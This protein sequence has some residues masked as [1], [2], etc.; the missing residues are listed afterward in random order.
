MRMNTMKAECF[1]MLDDRPQTKSA[2]LMIE[3]GVT[4][5][6]ADCYRSY[7]KRLRQEREQQKEAKRKQRR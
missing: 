3:F 6:T 4:K 1:K 2:T 5:G 7:H